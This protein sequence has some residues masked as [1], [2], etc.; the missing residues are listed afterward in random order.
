[1]ENK[2]IVDG[3]DVS[4]C[5]HYKNRNCI[6]DYCLTDMPF[7]EAK[8]ELNP[9]CKYKQL[10]REKQ[11]SQEARDIAIKEFNRA[12]E[13]KTL[14]KRKEQECEELKKTI[15]Y[16]CP[17]CGDEYLSPIGASLYEENN[18]LLPR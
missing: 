16:K 13:L 15:M 1:M 2:Q 14:L 18:K 5:K 9:N 11:N 6:A 8:C 10:Q 7:G 12:E 3:I 17:Q 4:G